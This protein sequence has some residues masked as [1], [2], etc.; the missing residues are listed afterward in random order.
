LSHQSLGDLKIVSEDFA[1]IVT[2]NTNVKCVLGINDPET[3]DYFARLFGTKTS[4]KL[5]E[6]M[7]SGSLW[8]P[9]KTGDG[10]VRD[11]EIY[12]VHPNKM[13]SYVNG[14]GVLHFVD[15]FGPVTEEVQF[16]PISAREEK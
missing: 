12:K 5:T 10:S 7:S 15:E 8:G 9:E 13:K 11:V 3:A 2:T 16:L 4:T 14:R 1:E 6:R